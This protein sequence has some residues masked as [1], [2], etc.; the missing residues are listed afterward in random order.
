MFINEFNDKTLLDAVQHRCYFKII[1]LPV[2]S[3]PSLLIKPGFISSCVNRVTVD[4]EISGL[5]MSSD[6]LIS[7]LS[8][9]AR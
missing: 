9:I 5:S 6:V 7:D 3:E 8:T 1:H 2:L 4:S